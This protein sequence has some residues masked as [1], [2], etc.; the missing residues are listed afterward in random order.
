MGFAGA[1]NIDGH[2]GWDQL[3][4]L[5]SFNVGIEAVQL[6]VII[7]IFPLLA[8]LRRRSHLGSLWMTGGIAV[9]VA[10]MGT[11]WFIGRVSGWYEVSSDIG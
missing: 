3:L 5:V 9:G 4:S 6:C 1:L 11:I 2:S 7:A 8:L 10:M